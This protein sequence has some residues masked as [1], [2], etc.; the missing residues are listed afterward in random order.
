MKHGNTI[1]YAFAALSITALSLWLIHDLWVVL[2]V[3]FCIT[4]VYALMTSKR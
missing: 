2:L 3:L 1:I 4:G